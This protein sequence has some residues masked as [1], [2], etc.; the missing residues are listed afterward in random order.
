MPC[1]WGPSSWVVDGWFLNVLTFEGHRGLWGVSQGALIPVMTYFIDD[2]PD[3]TN[4]SPPK[5]PASSY[6]HLGGEGLNLMHLG[7]MQTFCLQQS[8]IGQIY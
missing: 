1:L 5:G 3:L 7:G 2:P 8:L 4:Q 6:C